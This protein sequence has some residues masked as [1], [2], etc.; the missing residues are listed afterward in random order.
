MVK[1][2]K[3]D[4]DSIFKLSKTGSKGWYRTDC[5]FCEK[6]DH[7]GINF[8]SVVGSF[9]CYKC[10]EKGTLRTLLKKI[11]RLDILKDIKRVDINLHVVNKL[12]I[13]RESPITLELEEKERPLGFRRIYES[14]YIESRGIGNFIFNLNE[15]GYSKIESKLENF[16][17]IILKLESK[18]VGWIAR[19]T[20]S[21]E[22]IK[23]VEKLIGKKYYRYINSPNTDFSKYLFGI[24]ELTEKTVTIILV[25]GIFDKWRVD[26]LLE[27][28]KQDELKCLACFGKKISDH[29]IHLLQTKKIKNVILLYDND[30]INQS[31]K[32]SSELNKYFNVEVAFCKKGDPNEMNLE[33]LLETLSNTYNPTEFNLTFVTKKKL[34]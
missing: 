15:I 10:G 25:E 23:E 22:K 26:T 14:D 11:G 18:I 4:L 7:F 16:L 2:E 27:L 5:P 28:H 8:N 20:Y 13:E 17:I 24:N 3:E 21:N 33:E 1:L 31:K 34:E 30:A 29:Q 19:T 32:Y 12:S 6:K 9:N